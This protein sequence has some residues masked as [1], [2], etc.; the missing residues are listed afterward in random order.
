MGRWSHPAA[1][2]LAML[3]AV[4]ARYDASNPC[5]LVYSFWC[6][7]FAD[8]DD[9]SPRAPTNAVTSRNQALINHT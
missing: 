5:V 3:H 1:C 4:D 7:I 2:M 9:V 6:A 8:A